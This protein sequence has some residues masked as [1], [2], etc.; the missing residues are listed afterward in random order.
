MLSLKIKKKNE[1]YIFGA[2]G[3]ARSFY[4]AL[5]ELGY[6][7]IYIV[8]RSI[9]RFASWPNRN[10]I[11]RLKNFPDDPNENIVI[12]ATP[13]GMKQIRKKEYLSKINL[14][15]TKYYF[16]CVVSPKITKNIEI[17]KYNSIKI[18]SGYEISIEQ[19]IIQFKLYLK[20]KISKKLVT[21]IL[22]KNYFSE[23]TYKS[24]KNL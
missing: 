21:E 22:Q 23:K 2:G 5:N 15:K 6:K 14:K 3:Y 19:A 11:I 18:I 12:N 10:N 16:E 4:M 13:V 7:K 1:F 17:A 20:K 24:P 8:N 9:K